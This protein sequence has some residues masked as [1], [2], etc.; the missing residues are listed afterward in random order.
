M[1]D[2][3]ELVFRLFA[4]AVGEVE[5]IKYIAAIYLPFT[6]VVIHLFAVHVMVTLCL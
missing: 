3:S 2:S 1:K 5:F 6:F 4:N